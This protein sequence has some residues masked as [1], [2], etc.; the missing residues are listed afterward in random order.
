ML[1]E[2]KGKVHE[3]EINEKGHVVSKTE[4]YNIYFGSSEEDIVN[5]TVI[6][7]VVEVIPEDKESDA[8]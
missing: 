3:T 8:T 6:A 5:G 2:Y 7:E 1:I 4:G